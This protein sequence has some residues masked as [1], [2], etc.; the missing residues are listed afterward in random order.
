[1]F[2]FDWGLRELANMRHAPEKASKLDEDFTAGAFWFYVNTTF[3]N[4]DVQD[5]V[6]EQSVDAWAKTLHDKLACFKVSYE[7]AQ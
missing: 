3:F 1:M 2:E 4:H 5:L 6:L 7:N